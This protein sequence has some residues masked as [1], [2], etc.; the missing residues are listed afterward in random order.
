MTAA[1]LDDSAWDGF[2]DAH[3]GGAFHQLSGWARLKAAGGWTSRRLRFELPG[4]AAGAQVLVVRRRPLPWGF[5][6]LPRGPFGPGF[7]PASVQ[8][9]TVELARAFRGDRVAVLRAD[10]EIEAGGPVDPDG[11]FVSAL[12]ASGWRQAPAVQRSD[13][14]LLDLRAD[15]EALWAALGRSTRRDVERARRA[16]VVVRDAGRDRLPEFY[17]LLRA[18]ADQRHFIIRSEATFERL[19]DAFAPGD[20]ISLRFAEAP[21]GAAVAGYLLIRCGGRINVPW[22]ALSPDARPLRANHLLKWETIVRGRRDGAVEYNM[23]GVVSPGIEAFK[24][25]FGGRP[26]RFIGAWDLVLDPLGAASWRIA[27]WGAV[28]WS[29]FR[30]GRPAHPAADGDPG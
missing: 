6:Y 8:S 13:A 15:E 24:S 11:A 2:V 19:W 20:R 1:V 10:P 16:G 26:A 27:R 29:R 22:A 5:G 17:R 25:A 21:D 12:R 7:G 30:Y 18:T 3:A 14:W 28:A 4:G 23:G 9:L